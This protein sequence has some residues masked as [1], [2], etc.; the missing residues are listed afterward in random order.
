[1]PVSKRN[2]RAVFWLI[3]L[4]L[5]IAITP[6]VLTSSFSNQDISISFTEA[7]EVHLDIVKNKQKSKGFAQKKPKKSRFSAPRAKFDPKTY[8]APDWEQLGLSH[9]Q[10]EIVVKFSKRGI[11]SEDELA[12]I[13]VIP[14]QLF[15][16]IKDSIIYSTPKQFE[17]K[18]YEKRVQVI[19]DINS[20]NQEELE[21]LPGI[22]PYF[23]K[24]IVEYRDQLGGYTSSQQ[25]LEIWNFDNEKFERIKDYITLSPQLSPLNINTATLEELKN[26]PYISY[27]VANS[28]VKMRA[29]RQSYTKVS[30][31]KESK[32]INQELFNKIAPYLE[33][34]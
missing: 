18:E 1:M 15:R 33:C 24:K 23:A 5:L 9:K 13:F 10:A 11:R 30:D 7:K 29:Q 27:A 31:I 20:S 17:A 12:S 25:L 3:V 28:I 22:G 26:H 6:R 16:L 8:S 14:E 34:K 21:A 2:R 19:V 4:C 32:I